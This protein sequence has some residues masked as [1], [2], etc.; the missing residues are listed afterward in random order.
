MVSWYRD[1]LN[2]APRIEL[3]QRAIH[4]VVKP[5]DIVVELGTGLGTYAF[6][7]A[8]AGA[9]KVYAIEQDHIIHLAQQIAQRNGL[10][11]QVEFMKGHSLEIQLPEPADVLIFEDFDPFLSRWELD[12]IL[13]DA[14]QRHLKPSGI[15]MPRKLW[16]NIVPIE[17]EVFYNHFDLW[18]D[19]NYHLYGI[20]WSPM[21]SLLMNEIYY[22][23]LEDK[24]LLATPQKIHECHFHDSKQYVVDQSIDFTLQKSRT[25]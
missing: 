23:P 22:N 15:L 24:N 25:V 1:L 2:E 20:D 14:I 12:V 16:L 4:Q 10:A 13:L 7:A 18:R 17:S 6:F 5:G 8:Q 11:G 19:T 3:F 9:K 21:R